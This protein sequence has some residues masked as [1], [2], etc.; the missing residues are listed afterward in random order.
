MLRRLLGHPHHPGDRRDHQGRIGER[1]QIDE[2][3]AI[4]EALR[5]LRRGGQR[6]T[7]LAD[8][9]GADQRHQAHVVL[10][11]EA[12]EEG[13]LIFPPDQPRR[14]GREMDGDAGRGG[15]RHGDPSVARRPRS[16][17]AGGWSAMGLQAITLA[18]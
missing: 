5:H 17:L 9:A 10:G 1:R 13:Q 16:D 8:A 15:G 3:D 11:E 2:P 4:G 6:Q 7:S 14:L 12:A 18:A